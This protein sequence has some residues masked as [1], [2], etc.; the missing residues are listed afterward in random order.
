ML[1]I[2]ALTVMG[3]ARRSG[4]RRIAGYIISPAGP[5][6]TRINCVPGSRT[7]AATCL[8]A[9]HRKLRV[10]KLSTALVLSGRGRAPS[11]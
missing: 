7:I 6:D 9:V 3:W 8:Q 4:A 2:V 11:H 5:T 1:K 10:S